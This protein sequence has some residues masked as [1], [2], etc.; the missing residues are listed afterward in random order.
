MPKKR[1]IKWVTLIIWMLIIFLFSNQAYSGETTHSILENILPSIVNTNNIDILNFIIRK[2][3]H[4]TEYFI[5]TLLTISLL[6][7]YSL[8]ERVILL[9]SLIICFTYACTDEFHQAFVPGRTSL[10][11]DVLIDTSGGLIAVL[12]YCIINKYKKKSRNK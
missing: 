4:I 2:S 5:L 10:F 12:I 9:L 1:I 8:K 7:E 6:K 11:K 3:A